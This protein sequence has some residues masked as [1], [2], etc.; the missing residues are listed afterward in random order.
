ME[1]GV[2]LSDVHRAQARADAASANSAWGQGAVTALGRVAMDCHA[3]W[4]RCE[5]ET[6]DRRLDTRCVQTWAPAWHHY[7]PFSRCTGPRGAAV[8][9]T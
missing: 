6:L 1:Q 2:R 7:A 4:L 8:W 9:I 5:E 3:I